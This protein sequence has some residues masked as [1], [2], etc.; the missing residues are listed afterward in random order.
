MLNEPQ[1]KNVLKI[2][3]ELLF[4]AEEYPR[5]LKVYEKIQISD[6]SPENYYYQPILRIISHDIMNLSADRTF[7][8]DLPVS[9]QESVRLLNIIL[10][11]VK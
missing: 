11:L 2:Y 10:A 7:N 8:P 9:G 3:A 5:S 1:N 6:V 4:E